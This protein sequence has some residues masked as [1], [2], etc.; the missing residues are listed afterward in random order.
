MIS[1]E[2]KIG[3]IL[4]ADDLVMISESKEGLSKML[5]DLALF[6]SANGLKINA[7]KTKCMG[8]NITGRQIRCNIKCNDT[9]IT[10]VREYK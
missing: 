7:D 8:F 3:C 10:S 2:E 6:S 1:S 9:M 4:W 5:Q